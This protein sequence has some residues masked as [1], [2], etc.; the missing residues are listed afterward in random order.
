L[1]SVFGSVS[2]RNRDDGLG[3]GEQ[4]LALA[5]AARI[6]PG[7]AGLE[8]L[9]GRE[10]GGGHKGRDPE[11]DG[12][13]SYALKLARDGEATT[14]RLTQRKPKQAAKLGIVAQPGKGARR[15]RHVAPVLTTPAPQLQ[16]RQSD[17][18]L[19]IVNVG[20]AHRGEALLTR[21]PTL[22]P[23]Q[24][25]AVKIDPVKNGYFIVRAGEAARG[26][27]SPLMPSDPVAAAIAASCP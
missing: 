12:G 10:V 26:K 22:G 25:Q 15:A 1:R 19:A 21:L 23:E 6:A 8:R 11:G 7:E 14:V 16:S 3:L 24:P 2:H 13:I 17:V 18:A 20:L 5:G 4:K 27:T 9:S